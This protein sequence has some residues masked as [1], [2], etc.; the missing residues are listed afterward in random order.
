MLVAVLCIPAALALG[1]EGPPVSHVLPAGT[2]LDFVADDTVNADSVRPGGRFRVHLAQDLILDGTTIAPAGTAARLVILDKDKAT[3]GTVEL[4][5]ALAEFRLRPGELPV[6]P[7]DAVVS[8]VKPGQTIAAQMQGSV[9]RVGDRTVVHVPVPVELS[10]DEP[11]SAFVPAPMKT[12]AP[13]LPPPKR[14]AS[15]TPLPTTFVSPG[16]SPAPATPEATATP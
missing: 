14:G 9:E 10:S 5:V 7:L 6:A 15:P 11:H 3:D 8:T 2:R 4:F 13:L 1:A 12:A 16:E